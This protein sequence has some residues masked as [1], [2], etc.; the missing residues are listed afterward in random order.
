MNQQATIQQMRALK[1]SG[2]LA[3]YQNILQL[4]LDL[5]PSADQLLAQLLEAE[6]LER[7]NRKT[8]SCVR[9][10]HFRYQAAIEEIQYLPQRE[11]DKNLIL[12]LADTSFI[13]RNE[14]VFITGATGCGKSYIASALGYEA[15]QRGLRVGYFSMPK[16]LQR[17]QFAR[18]D[19]SII[20]ELSRLEKLQL[21]ILDDWGLHPLDTSAKLSLLQLI[22]DRHGKSSTIITSQLPVA[23]WF[24]YI[25]EPTLADAIMDR[26]MQQLH[27]I[28]LKGESLRKPQKNNQ[29]TNS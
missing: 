24:D 21:L 13:K 10:A 27:R 18:A 8:L 6:L 15:C 4:P 5:Q 17:L 3:T 11:L 2:M 14:N 16:L 9:A 26:L 29:I 20:K 19:G 28:E 22:E 25:A 7:L 12:R 23:Q 1:L